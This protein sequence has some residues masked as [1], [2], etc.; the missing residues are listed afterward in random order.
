[1]KQMN[2]KRGVYQTSEVRTPTTMAQRGKWTLQT[3]I[4][5]TLLEKRNLSSVEDKKK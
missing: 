2:V 1:M 3:P 5:K 4:A